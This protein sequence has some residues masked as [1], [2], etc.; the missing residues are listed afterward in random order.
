MVMA[1]DTYKAMGY[2]VKNSYK[3]CSFLKRCQVWLC[4]PV[5]PALGWLGQKAEARQGNR[6]LSV[7]TSIWES[8]LIFHLM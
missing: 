7:M 6:V 3:N 8:V 4:M 5:I 2:S 1:K